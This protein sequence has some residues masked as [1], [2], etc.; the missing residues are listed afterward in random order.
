RSRNTVVVP[1][2]TVEPPPVVPVQRTAPPPQPEPEQQ[3]KPEPAAPSK[4]QLDIPKSDGP[5]LVLPSSRMD[6]KKQ[7]SKPA[8]ETPKFDFSKARPV[9]SDRRREQARPQAPAN[10]KTPDPGRD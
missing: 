8:P 5:G 10:S 4:V 3:T 6:P 9:N 2:R 1:E 7:P